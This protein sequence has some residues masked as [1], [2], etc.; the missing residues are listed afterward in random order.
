MRNDHL[1]NKIRPISIDT[2]FNAYA[3]APA[4]GFVYDS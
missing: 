1:A 3:E 4:W 2:T